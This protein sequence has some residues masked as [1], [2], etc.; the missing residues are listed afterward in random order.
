[1]QD[2]AFIGRQAILDK[3]QKIVAYELLFRHHGAATTAD[4]TDDLH[5]GTR[6]ITNTLSNMGTEW[7]L[8]DKQAFINIA[9][10]MLESEFLEL[11]PAKRVVLEIL[12][13]VTITPELLVRGC[14]VFAKNPAGTL[15]DRRAIGFG[16]GTRERCGDGCAQSKQAHW[17]TREIGA[18]AIWCAQIAADV[19]LEH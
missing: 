1:M 13:S 8:G 9:T 12:E 16:L 17:H 2:N 11:L 5:A 14:S 19:V 6:V 4:I 3:Q 18:H 7:L 10:P 15:A